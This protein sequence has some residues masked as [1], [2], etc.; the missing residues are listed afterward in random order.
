MIV[1]PVREHTRNHEPTW[2]EPIGKEHNAAAV[3]E[4][5]RPII[6]NHHSWSINWD[7]AYTYYTPKFYHG[8]ALST[9]LR[10]GA[11]QERSSSAKGGLYRFERWALKV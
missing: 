6:V 7:T 9:L 10:R 11:K 4:V 8:Q 2:I 5:A 3:D 1:C